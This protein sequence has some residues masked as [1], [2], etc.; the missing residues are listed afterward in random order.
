MA[1]KLKIL[2][3]S[4]IDDCEA[5]DYQ[6]G[7]PVDVNNPHFTGQVAVLLKNDEQSHPY[8]N[9]ESNKGITWSIQL[10]GVLHDDDVDCDNLVFGNQF[11]HP[12][13]QHLPWGSAMAVKFIKYL[14]PTLTEDLQSDTPWAFSPLCSTVER[15]NVSDN[16]DTSKMKNEQDLIIEEDISCLIHKDETSKPK[17]GNAS[18][19]KKWFKSES[20]RKGL[21]LS[22]KRVA[23]DFAKG[24]INF[25]TLS[26]SFPEI[27]LNIGLLK[28][29]DGQPVRFYLRNSN[30]G[31]DYAVIQFII[32]DVGQD[33]PAQTKQLAEEKNIGTDN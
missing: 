10:C 3:G 17:C 6:G 21:N 33:A 32:E 28:H 29:W 20:R 26:L 27:G 16:S 4:T 24:F 11:S 1:I 2:A 13:R 19:R 8:F 9:D 12:I 15:L 5:V 18:A 23:F 14:D 22:K 30:T 25:S 7:K 31:V